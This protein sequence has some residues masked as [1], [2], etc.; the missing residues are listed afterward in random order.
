MASSSVYFFET[1]I[2]RYYLH[3]GKA[4][5]T[6]AQTICGAKN[7]TLASWQSG[8]EE[9]YRIFELGWNYHYCSEFWVGVVR[10]SNSTHYEFMD[11][12]D[13]QPIDGVAFDDYIELM[14]P[15]CVNDFRG[16]CAALTDRMVGPFLGMLQTERGPR[17]RVYNCLG[18]KAFLCKE[19]QPPGPSPPSPPARPLAG[20]VELRFQLDYLTLVNR[21]AGLEG[22]RA[23]VESQ[24][25]NYYRSGNVQKVEGQ[26]VYQDAKTDGATVVRALVHLPTV[27]DAN[28]AASFLFT[29]V[30][31]PSIIFDDTFRAKY[32]IST[33][34]R[35]TL[36]QVV[37]I[38]GLGPPTL[39][40]AQ[41]AG[42]PNT[43]GRTANVAL[44]A[45]L[46][47]GLGLA[48]LL[49]GVAAYVVVSRRRSARNAVQEIH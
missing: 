13:V 25:A 3:R 45:G 46:G 9:L 29:L 8:N 22:F 31:A 33:P 19:P 49:G 23:A 20:R 12:G 41:I 10:R 5:W 2:A 14:D 40:G 48:L 34:I 42:A 26:E 44:G 1:R 16:C 35:S 28:G 32:L 4:S 36:L 27:I 24:V 37:E 21:P 18:T 43:E 15:A 47:V 38:Q 17:L 6:T 30:N 39:D 7:R 11:G